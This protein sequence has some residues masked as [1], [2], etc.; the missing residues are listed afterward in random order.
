MINGLCEGM[1]CVKGWFVWRDVMVCMK[2]CITEDDQW[3]VWLS[4]LHGWIVWMDV[5]QTTLSHKPSLHTNHLSFSVLHII[6]FACSSGL[7]FSVLHPF[8][9]TIH[10]NQVITQT[11]YSH[12]PD[13]HT[14]KPFTHTNQIFTQTRWIL[15]HKPFIIL[16][17]T[18]LHTNHPHKPDNH[19]IHLFTQTR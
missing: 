4:D 7:S 5:T 16:S 6:G 12:K 14:N 2:G 11:I 9:Q 15:S 13:N 19:K 1:V 18:S 3:F 17:I 10:I 8:T